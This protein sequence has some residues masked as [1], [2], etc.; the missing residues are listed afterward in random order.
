MPNKNQKRKEYEMTTK[1]NETDE[2]STAQ[3]I[4]VQPMVM[5]LGN[6]EVRTCGKHLTNDKRHITAEI[7]KWHE[8]KETCHTIAYWAR[9]EEGFYI[10]FIG[11][12]PFDD[13]SGDIF[14]KIAK[15]GQEHLDEY[16]DRLDA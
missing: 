8:N 3:G 10:K 11:R 7:I 6:I 14:W 5:R 16:F 4:D 2:K 9:D 1:N 13:C 12:R 15:I